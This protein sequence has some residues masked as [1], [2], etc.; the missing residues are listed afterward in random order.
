MRSRLLMMMFGLLAAASAAVGGETRTWTDKSASYSIQA[1]FVE[2]NGDLVVLRRQDGKELRVPLEKL[3][4]ADQE[5][6]RQIRS[7]KP[8]NP[9][10]MSEPSAATMSQPSD[11]SDSNEPAGQDGGA[12][13][14]VVA[15]GYGT[16]EEDARDN[17][18][19]NA[20]QQA[21]G[22]LVDATTVVENDKL[23]TEKVLTYSNGYVDRFKVLPTE[24]AKNLIVV[25]IAAQVRVRALSEKLQALSIAVRQNV[26]GSSLAAAAAT[27]GQRDQDAAAMLAELLQGFPANC[28]ALTSGSLRTGSADA[29]GRTDL[30]VPV[31][32]TVDPKRYLQ[33]D[34]GLRRLL[35]K[36]AVRSKS[37]S[38]VPTDLSV[39][40]EDYDFYHKFYQPGGVR[41]L[42]FLGLEFGGGLS[43]MH[44]GKPDDGPLDTFGVAL[45]DI[46]KSSQRRTSWTVFELGR[47]HFDIFRTRFHN[48]KW[49]A[50]NGQKLDPALTLRVRLLDEASKALDEEEFLAV[51][52]RSKI[53]P[54]PG[55]T[56][57]PPVRLEGIRND[58]AD[59]HFRVSVSL[60]LMNPGLTETGHAGSN[61]RSVILGDT[62]YR[63]DV[64]P[65]FPFAPL[66]HY[67]FWWNSAHCYS[68]EVRFAV[69]FKGL[70]VKTVEKVKNVECSVMADDASLEA[71]A[72]Q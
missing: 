59:D 4:P 18:F 1:E 29:D 36:M 54:R 66:F 43:K 39:A 12:L 13:R 60:D 15:I 17:A 51:C 30:T 3:S 46:D 67:D 26:D 27:K 31:T 41:L 44:F 7:S 11:E 20:V 42:A 68:P 23:L 24:K 57:P 50:Y 62:I 35:T 48:Y 8:E 34:S 19:Q 55:T 14:E 45:F 37:Y 52:V 33:F 40:N 69:T 5:H 10:A 58:P 53:V 21:I 16:T 70:E 6:V 64:V 61:M 72:G 28:L 63:K 32:V 22:V 65:L 49:Q 56:A 9:F 71:T 38:L 47:E 25:K 2:L